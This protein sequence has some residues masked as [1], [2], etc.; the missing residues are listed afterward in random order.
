M[1]EQYEVKVAVEK[2]LFTLFS[3]LSTTKLAAGV[4][5]VVP[6]GRG[7]AVGVVREACLYE[8]EENRSYQLKKLQ[9]VIDEEPVYSSNMLKLADFLSSYY[10]HPIGEVLKAMLPGGSN[11]KRQLTWEKQ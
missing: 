4:R 9:K 8:S 5:V 6:F 11:L 10:I 3:Y 2:P 1:G 7:K